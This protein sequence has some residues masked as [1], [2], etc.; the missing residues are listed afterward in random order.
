MDFDAALK[1]DPNNVSARLTRASARMELGDVDGAGADYDAIIKAR[2][3]AAYF[4]VQRAHFLMR[5]GEAKD[6]FAD[7]ASALKIEPD[8]PEAISARAIL[9]LDAGEL[10]AALT[11]A[12]QAV[13]L[14]PESGGHVALRG[15]ARHIAG[16]L[17]GAISDYREAGKLDPTEPFD[18]LLLFLALSEAGKP[19]EAKA[20]LRGLLARWPA[21]EWPAPLARHLLGESS[22]DDLRKAA[23]SGT[24]VLRKY[25]DFDWH[26][27]LGASAMIRGDKARAR[28]YLEH[29]VETD[30]NQFLEYNIARMFLE[31]LGGRAYLETN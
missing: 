17:D 10:D 21:A 27:Y 20:A 22:E 26:F 28:A 7:I 19:E 24:E 8:M 29:V 9:H 2:P 4:R 25:Q 14:D 31:R 1:V 11:D 6:A 5:I 30:L 18:P 13:E 15:T 23:E 3:D 16:D 12:G